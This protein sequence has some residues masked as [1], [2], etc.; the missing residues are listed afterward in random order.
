MYQISILNCKNGNTL[1]SQLVP[2]RL[3]KLAVFSKN[4][5]N[6]IFPYVYVVLNLIPFYICAICERVG[7]LKIK[8]P[9]FQYTADTG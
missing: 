1:K 5:N 6:G 4:A 8:L 3:E 7:V 9:T 2:V